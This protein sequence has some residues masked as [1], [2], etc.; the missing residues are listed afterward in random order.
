ML[1]VLTFWPTFLH[2]L[3]QSLRLNLLIIYVGLFQ[4]VCDPLYTHD[5][6]DT[7]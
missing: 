2:I 1:Q 6:M 7:Q 3:Y 4:L 5:Y